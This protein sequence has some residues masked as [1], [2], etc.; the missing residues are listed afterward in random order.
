MLNPS[1]SKADYKELLSEKVAQD[2]PDNSL[3][4]MTSKDL[5][6]N[7]LFALCMLIHP[8]SG[9]IVL[10]FGNKT[11]AS[12]IDE[13][14]MAMEKAIKPKQ[15]FSKIKAKIDTFIATL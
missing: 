8:I 2:M 6:V 7:A 9:S 11:F 12:K 14:A 10:Y 15:L 3:P 13:F 1:R 5:A 4:T